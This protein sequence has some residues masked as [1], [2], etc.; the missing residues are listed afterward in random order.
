MLAKQKNVNNESIGLSGRSLERQT[1]PKSCRIATIAESRSRALKGVKQRS[2]VKE[3]QNL[4]Q[5]L[6]SD[7]MK[8]RRCRKMIIKSG[9]L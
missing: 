2:K 7:S 3:T 6:K 4:L 9:P 8:L 1:T 5:N